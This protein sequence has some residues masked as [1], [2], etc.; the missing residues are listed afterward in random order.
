DVAARTRG[1]GRLVRVVIR[2]LVTRPASRVIRRSEEGRLGMVSCAGGCGIARLQV[3]R[4]TVLLVHRVGLDQPSRRAAMRPPP[5]ER[6][7]PEHGRG[8]GGEGQPHPQ[9]AKP[10]PAQVVVSLDALGA[11]LRFA[12]SGHAQRVV[13]RRGNLTKGRRTPRTFTRSERMSA[14]ARKPRLA[15]K[16]T[17]SSWSTPSP[18]TPAA[19]ISLRPR[20]SGTL[21]GKI[22]M[23]LGEMEEAFCGGG[24]LFVKR[25]SKAGVTRSS[26]SPSLK[27]LKSPTGTENGPWKVPFIPSGKNGRL[28][29]PCARS[30]KATLPSRSM[31]SRRAAS[32]NWSMLIVDVDAARNRAP[33]CAVLKNAAV[34]AFCADTSK[35]NVGASCVRKIPSMFP[36]RSTIVMLTRARSPSGRRMP[37]RVRFAWRAPCFSRRCTCAAVSPGGGGGS[38]LSRGG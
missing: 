34:R 38:M 1:G 6:R 10:V 35:P 16:A 27:M 36:A 18:L 37:A 3:A 29:N 12:L 28:R 19:P 23:P 8:E 14:G 9:A 26:C 4:S 17:M 32:T 33:A 13:G 30:L 25:S 31:P 22:W 11:K 2:D 20:E 24:I 5:K 15:A 21:P 7:E